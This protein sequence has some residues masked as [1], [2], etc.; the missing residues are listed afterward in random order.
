MIVFYTSGHGFG[1]AARDV[2]VIDALRRHAPDVRVTVRTSVPL[3]F[4]ETAARRHV[5]VQ[6]LQTDSGLA[7]IDSLTIDE[8]ETLRRACRFH[9]IF[10]YR[11]EAE[12]AWLR[13]EG[14]AIVVA[15]VPPLAFAAAAAA[16]LPSIALANFTWDWIYQALPGF[17]AQAPHVLG[18]IVGA[19][20][21]ATCALRLPLHG[22]FG[23]MSDVVRDIPL[24]ARHSTHGRAAVRQALGLPST[25]P[26]VLASF[27]G[28]GLRLPYESLAADPRFVLLL[29][30][31]E[32]EGANADV[33]RGPHARCVTAGELA[34]RRLRYEDLVA[35]ADVVV[36]KPGYGIVSECI[37]N[38]TAL[39]YT[40]RGRMA[41]YDVFIDA[42]PR[43]LR[44]RFIAP[45]DLLA[46][47]WADPV[48]ALL[49]QPPAP[50]TTM[51]NGAEVAADFILRGLA[52]TPTTS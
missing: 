5:D 37:A 48:D 29:T 9:D 38:D 33:R 18:Q 7:Q 10:D 3:W 16:D 36:S 20:R 50:V 6:P 22:G 17:E 35:A 32:A 41:E 8:P 42:M 21:K 26:V 13:R 47:S 46:G 49:A 4:F 43:M 12:A 11:V 45:D 1:H 2:E 31:F 24:I 44:C 23:A 28:H 14:A 25:R 27:G 40:S 30:T 19:Y 51:T 34:N 39:L 52:R 15:D